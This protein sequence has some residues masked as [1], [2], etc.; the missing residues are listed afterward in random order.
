MSREISPAECAVSMSDER[1]RETEIEGERE[2][3]RHNK[4]ATKQ[5][6]LSI[7]LKYLTNTLFNNAVCGFAG[8]ILTGHRV[9]D[10]N[11]GLHT[12]NKYL[13]CL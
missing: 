12:N 8:S 6:V 1:E 9:Q 5:E 2:R 3:E 13:I 10:V 4:A 11:N 7:Y